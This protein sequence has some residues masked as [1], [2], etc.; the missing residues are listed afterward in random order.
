MLEIGCGTGQATLPMAGRGYRITAVEL[1]PEMAALARRHLAAFHTVAVHTAALETWPLPAEPFDLVMAAT[2][3]HWVDPAVRWHRAAAALR[4]GGA[5]AV[6][7]SRHVA[8]GDDAFFA[9]AQR[10]Y[11]RHMPATAPGQ[12]LPAAAEVADDAAGLEATGLFGPPVFRRYVWE[13]ALSIAAYIDLLHTYSDHRA[14]ARADR[15]ALFACLTELMEG[16]FGGHVRK[17]YLT[18]LMV[19]RRL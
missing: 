1:G 17:A 9:A 8:G 10:C 12:R 16:R 4:S 13:T 6:F 14:L 19:A 18:Q 5:V 11:E 3:F 15:E 7:G 2:A